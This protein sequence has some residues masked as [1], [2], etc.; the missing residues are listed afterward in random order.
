[1]DA[2]VG[3]MWGLVFV[4]GYIHLTH[5]LFS[6]SGNSCQMLLV[7]RLRDCVHSGKN[8]IDLKEPY[9]RTQNAKLKSLRE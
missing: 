7:L 2:K 9:P 4:L 5:L 1:M 8:F 6:C 3:F